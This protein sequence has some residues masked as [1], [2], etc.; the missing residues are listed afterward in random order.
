MSK[1]ILAS[2][3]LA[4]GVVAA[5]SSASAAGTLNVSYSDNAF[6]KIFAN[7]G[8]EFTTSGLGG[9]VTLTSGITTTVDVL[10]ISQWLGLYWDDATYS[11]NVNH[12]LTL[13]GVG[14]NFSQF[15]Q[16]FD[17]FSPATSLGGAGPLTFT[18]PSGTIAVTMNGGNGFGN[19]GADLLYTEAG[20]PEPAT[21]AL[22]IGGFGMAGA[23]LRRRR[24]AVAA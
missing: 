14:G 10:N 9:N 4:I 8:D 1:R 20:V 6:T 22:M 21:W 16:V 17:Y 13:N 3:A 5:A 12:T 11:A 2:M 23:V 24:L 15:W 19:Y 7:P 18:L